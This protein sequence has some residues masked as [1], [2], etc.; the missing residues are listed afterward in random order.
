MDAR[1]TIHGVKLPLN[2]GLQ[3]FLK[4]MILLVFGESNL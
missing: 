3:L 2:I 1:I 4:S